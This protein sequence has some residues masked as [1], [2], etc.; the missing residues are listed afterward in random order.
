MFFNRKLILVLCMLI[1]L[2]LCSLSAVVAEPTNQTIRVLI[3]NG[4]KVAQDSVSGTK[5]IL[6]LSNQKN[7][8]PGYNFSYSTSNIINST[9][10]QSYNVLVM[11]GGND[12]ITNYNGT[13]I[14]S[15]DPNAIRNFVNNGGG[16]VGICA[17]AFAGAYYTKDC[18]YGWGVAPNVNCL[19]AYY[20]NNTSITINSAGKDIMGK[21]GRITTLY[22]NGPA[23]NASGM[24]RVLATYDGIV[25][26]G[27]TIIAS[28]MA[29]IV[30]DY[31]GRGRSVLIGPHPEMDPQSPDI[32]ANLIKWASSNI[33]PPLTGYYP[34]DMTPSIDGLPIPPVAINAVN[35]VTEMEDTSNMVI[36]ANSLEKTQVMGMQKTG[37]PV[38]WIIIAILI[39]LSGLYRERK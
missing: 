39:V 26:S 22:W 10:L 13:T 28:G 3:Y 14:A 11:P 6:D 5:N 36:A 8:V 1:L 35:V 24:A 7:L 25:N 4:D 34:P 2:L 20:E 27:N 29:A 33:A 17:G 9:T 15:I 12:Y 37:I 19:Q 18:Y 23:M 31:Y 32:V 38:M 16:Y 21:D 30:I